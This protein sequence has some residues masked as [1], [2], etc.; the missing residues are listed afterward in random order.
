MKECNQCG[1]CCI[2]YSDG[3]LSASARDIEMWR[4]FRPD[5]Y[6]YVDEGVIWV[7]P[8]DG[9]Q[10]T[11]CP[12]LTQAPDTQKYTCQIYDDRPEDCR[13]YPVSVAQMYKDE[14]E[15]LEACDI[16]EPKKAQI[17]LDKL[18]SNSRP[19]LGKRR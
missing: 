1:K 15:M 7:N 19:P 17:K 4:I 8:S 18:M 11:R 9:K 6:E 14:C 2:N 16:A 3:G 10:L 5:I 13:H 12:W